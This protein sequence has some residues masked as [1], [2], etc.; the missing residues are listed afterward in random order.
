MADETGANENGKSAITRRQLEVLGEHIRK[1]RRSRHLSQV[2]LALQAGFVGAYYS[3][4]ERGKLN[5]SVINLIKIAWAL[6]VEIGALFPPMSELTENYEQFEKERGVSEPGDRID[7]IHQV[8]EGLGPIVS[9]GP[10]ETENGEQTLPELLLS[11]GTVARMLGVTRRTVDR[12]VH[13]GLLVPAARVEEQK[14]RYTSLFRRKDIDRAIR[15]R[16]H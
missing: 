7:H 4:I 8:T 10:T 16:Q 2:Q 3:A 11:T 14:G 15:E 12:W 5:F 13:S 6:G 1:L 9:G